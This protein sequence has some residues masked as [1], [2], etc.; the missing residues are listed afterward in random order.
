M[1]RLC[2][3]PS[4]RKIVEEHTAH[5][6]LLVAVFQEEILS[7]HCLKHRVPVALRQGAKRIAAGAVEVLRPRAQTV[8]ERHVHA[9]TKPADPSLAF[10][11]GDKA[12]HVHVRCRAS[13]VRGMQHQRDPIASRR[14]RPVAE[15]TAVL[16]QG[17]AGNDTEMTRAFE[18]IGL[19][20]LRDA[21][22]PS[23]RAQ[24]SVRKGR[25]RRLRGVRRRCSFAGR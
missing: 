8:V 5:A 11:R 13:R 7:H 22:P 14:G 18:E 25:L 21:A 9:A 2:S 15:R 3:K 12:A 19:L 17:L 16:R 4:S 1:A 10:L 6:A 23:R 20:D 24:L